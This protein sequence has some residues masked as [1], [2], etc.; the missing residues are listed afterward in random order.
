MKKKYNNRIKLDMI[1]RVAAALCRIFDF[2]DQVLGSI[3]PYKGHRR[4]GKGLLS[5]WL[6]YT[7][8]TYGYFRKKYEIPELAIMFVSFRYIYVYR[9][10]VH[11]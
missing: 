9:R 5:S 7:D 3:V 4:E 8:R 10:D 11:E 1:D 2:V 6:R